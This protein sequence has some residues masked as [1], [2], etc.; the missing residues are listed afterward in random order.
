VVQPA[1]RSELTMHVLTN[2]T[3]REKCA[4]LSQVLEQPADWEAT[5]ITNNKNKYKKQ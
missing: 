4:R 2:I 5:L 3:K 1:K